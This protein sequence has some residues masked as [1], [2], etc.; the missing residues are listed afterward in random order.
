MLTPSKNLKKKILTMKQTAYDDGMIAQRRLSDIEIVKLNNAHELKVIDLQTQ[1][2][3]LEKTISD[4]E[5]LQKDGIDKNRQADKKILKAQEIVLH[6]Q[7]AID[8][9]SDAAA[10]S[11]NDMEH[12]RDNIE[13]QV[14]KIME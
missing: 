12:L 6:V 7:K 10:R 3:M 11:K 5:A 14:K 13:D 4:M 2:R 9:I 8:N 1:I